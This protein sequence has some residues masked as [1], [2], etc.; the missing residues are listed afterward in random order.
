[1]DNSPLRKL[2]LELRLNIYERALYVDGGVKVT[3]NRPR[4]KKRRLSREKYASRP[5]PLALQSTCKA[6]ANETADLVFKVNTSWIFAQMDD[7][8]TSW[9]KRLQQWRQQA[10]EKCLERAHSVQY[11]IGEWCSNVECFPRGKLSVMLLS[12]V[13]AM[14]QNL[15]KQL[16][17]CEQTFKLRLNWSCPSD[18]TKKA[19][20]KD[21]ASPLTFL[22]PIWTDP[23]IIEAAFPEKYDYDALLEQYRTSYWEAAGDDMPLCSSPAEFSKNFRTIA[24]NDIMRLNWLAEEIEIASCIAFAQ[25]TK[26]RLEVY[27]SDRQKR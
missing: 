3:L 11:D 6:I 15:A 1:M 9:G 18:Q 27:A 21:R 24:H 25:R 5:H 16:R 12:A 13:G 22:V 4:S 14:Y 8:S 20:G 17:Q 7:D 19:G 2:P 23:R 26:E 10:G